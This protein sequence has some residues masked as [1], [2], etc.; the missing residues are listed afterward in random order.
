MDGS[1]RFPKKSIVFDMLE[2]QNGSIFE[3]WHKHNGSGKI[4][5]VHKLSARENEMT[6]SIFRASRK[7]V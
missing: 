3:S 4:A 6:N 2:I 1:T 5:F 7:N